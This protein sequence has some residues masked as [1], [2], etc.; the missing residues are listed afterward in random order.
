VTN[1]SY[2]FAAPEGSYAVVARASDTS[3]NTDS[4]PA[5]RTAPPPH[6]VPKARAS[7]RICGQGITPCE[8]IP[9]RRGTVKRGIA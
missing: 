5:T 2:A 9:L 7:V 6:L 3:N 8:P 1:W 4:T